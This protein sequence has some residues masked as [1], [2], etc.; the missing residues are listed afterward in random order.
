MSF[1]LLVWYEDFLDL[2]T[3]LGQIA[4]V[5][6]KIIIALLLLI[7]SFAI[8]NGLCKGMYKR[9]EKRHADETI[10]KVGTRTI[11]IVLKLV[12]LT[13]LVGFLGIETASISALVASLGVGISLAVQGTLSNFAG[14][15]II[16]VMRP[17]KLGD[18]IVASGA[19]GTV[20]DIKLFYTTLVTPDNKQISVPN[21]TL[22]NNVIVNT[23]AKDTR[24]LQLI[25]QVAYGTDTDKVKELIKNTC[26]EN[27]LVL[28]D[29][30]PFVELSELNESSLDFTVRVWC[31]RPDYW[32]VNFALLDSIKK[33]LDANGIEIPYKQIDVHIDNN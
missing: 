8:I 33:T 17:F 18:Y 5:A 4:I 28:K 22:A 32:T 24:R 29:P 6:I 16:I 26:A 3:T 10:A 31:N 14:G 2:D 7:I 9:M 1:N 21:G 12:V 20:E 11:R 13:C 23:S 19:E 27:E 15:V 25:I 30:A